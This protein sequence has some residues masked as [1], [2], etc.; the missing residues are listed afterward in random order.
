DPAA[1]WA[2]YQKYLDLRLGRT[3]KAPRD[4]LAPGPKPAPLS[5]GLMLRLGE[6][7]FRLDDQ[8]GCRRWYD[9]ALQASQQS[10]KRPKPTAQASQD[11]AAS[12]SALGDL[13]LM[14]GEASAALEHYAKARALYDKLLAGNKENALARR[15]VA[16]SHYRLGAAYLRMNEGGKAEEHFRES[17]KTRLGLAKEDALHAYHQ[18]GLMINQARC[19]E[20]SQA[21]ERAE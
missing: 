10:G 5:V 9:R 1:A 11:L 8:D 15:N 12:L 2:A 6:L 7:A 20:H 18:I 17:L 3:F 21:S 19:G 16:I 14:T 13:E 4:A